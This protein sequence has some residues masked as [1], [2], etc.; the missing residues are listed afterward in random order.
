MN[1]F[2]GLIGIGGLLLLIMLR[3]PIGFAMAVTGLCGFGF[4]IS[5]VAGLSLLAKDIFNIF[6][7]Y[8]LSV[9]PLFV[10]MGQLCFNSGLGERVYQATYKILGRFPGGLTM[11]TIAGCAGFASICGSTTATAATMGTV[12]I[13]EMKKYKYDQALAT[14][15]VAAGGTLGILIPPSSVFIIYGIMTQ[16]SIGKLFFAGVIPGLILTGLFI[17]SIYIICRVNPDLG[18]AGAP[19]TLREILRTLLGLGEAAVLFGL[20]MGGLFLGWFTPTEAGGIGAFGAL[21]LA[22]I[23][24]RLTWKGFLLSFDQT[25]RISCMIFIIIA[26][27]VIFGRFLAVTRLPFELAAWVDGLALPPLLILICILFIY[28]I[29]GCFMDSL[30][31]MMLTIS[32]FFPVVVRLGYDPIWFGVIIVIV[33]EI[34]AITPPVGINVFVISGV[35]PDVPLQTIFKGISYFLGAFIVLLLLLICFPQLALLLPALVG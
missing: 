20:V 2:V 26:G 5:P 24:G 23:T 11:A 3:M 10:L 35:A 30:A 27:A 18:P 22:V 33:T 25:I 6:D 12:S 34:G 15:A 14:G 31:F 21:A 19:A 28:L 32:I 7:S 9:V 17:I 29:G 4:M 1:L 8:A 13:P 16:Q